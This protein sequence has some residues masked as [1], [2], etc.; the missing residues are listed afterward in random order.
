MV[1]V[2]QTDGLR[3]L[4]QTV[5]ASAQEL[6]GGNIICQ[7]VGM[8]DHGPALDLDSQPPQPLECDRQKFLQERTRTISVR[9][10]GQRPLDRA[11]SESA[12]EPYGGRIFRQTVDTADRGPA[13]GSDGQ[14]P[15]LLERG[16]QNYVQERQK[17]A[18]VQ[19]GESNHGSER[20]APARK[21]DAGN[22]QPK[23]IATL[24]AQDGKQPKKSIAR[25]TAPNGNQ[26][27]KEIPL[28]VKEVGRTSRQAVKGAESS[29]K[30][31][32]AGGRSAQAMRQTARATVQA[33]Q[34]AVQAAGAARRTAATAGKAMAMAKAKAA[35][36]ALRGGV[37]AIRSLALLLA[38]GAARHSP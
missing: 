26:R 5:S 16:R 32:H 33:Q 37:S 27:I 14:P 31:L 6:H 4:D 3:R 2:R 34:R 30:A 24:S 28:R 19:R 12:Q 21:W 23:S 9:Q 18:A 36:S 20:A 17:K 35:V 8:A 11:V 38:S 25:G 1:S 10:E 13:P 22:A 29:G 15:R 7:T